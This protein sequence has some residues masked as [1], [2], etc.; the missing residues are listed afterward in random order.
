MCNMCVIRVMH[1][2][3]INCTGKFVKFFFESL[4]NGTFTWFTTVNPAVVAHRAVIELL[5]HSSAASLG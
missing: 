2:L 1:L 3:N 5:P 4:T